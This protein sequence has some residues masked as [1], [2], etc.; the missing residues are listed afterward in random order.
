MLAVEQEI[1]IEERR[2]AEL[3]Q[4][5]ADRKSALNRAR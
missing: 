2:L 3:E 1:A 5:I 4:N